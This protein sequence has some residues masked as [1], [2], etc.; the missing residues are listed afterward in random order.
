M[1]GKTVRVLVELS[2][3]PKKLF[4]GNAKTSFCDWIS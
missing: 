3:A 4:P 2:A 1:N